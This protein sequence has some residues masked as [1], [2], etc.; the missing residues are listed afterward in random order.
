MYVVVRAKDCFLAYHQVTMSVPVLLLAIFICF[1]CIY[2]KHVCYFGC[3][4]FLQT[5]TTIHELCHCFNKTGNKVQKCY[6]LILL[7]VIKLIIV[8]I[9]FFVFSR[10]HLF[11]LSMF[12]DVTEIVSLPFLSLNF[13]VLHCFLIFDKHG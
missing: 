4:I 7:F 2:W 1:I 10:L 9:V 12:L 3:S 6:N 5:I 8:I 13:Q 11:C